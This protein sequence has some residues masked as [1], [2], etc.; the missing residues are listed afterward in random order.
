MSRSARIDYT[1][2][3]LRRQQIF[4]ARVR[5][6]TQPFYE[7]YREQQ[8]KLLAQGADAYLPQEMAELS[9]DLDTIAR[10]LNL[11]P[12]AAREVSFHVGRYIHGLPSILRE[13]K[14][15]FAEQERQKQEALDRATCEK[16]A[17]LQKTYYTFIAGL[18]PAD[19]HFA[20]HALADIEKK[21]QADAIDSES[22]LSAMLATAAREASRKAEVWRKKQQE[23][24]AGKA[25]A[26]RIDDAI[27]KVEAESIVAPQEKQVLIQNLNGLRASLDAGKDAAEV[28]EGAEAADKAADALMVTIDEQ[29]ALAQD[30][31]HQLMTQGFT[32]QQPAIKDGIVYLTGIAPDGTQAD[33]TIDTKGKGSYDFHGFR[34]QLCRQSIEEF[35]AQLSAIYN[36]S[37]FETQTIWEN[38]D[39]I[40]SGVDELP[41]SE[42]SL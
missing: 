19:A 32:L 22:N 38:L 41:V 15:A 3:K 27:A 8:A 25:A 26:S 6:N 36:T 5:R 2:E 17:G 28:L 11:D 9:H 14:K 4:E 30:I 10:L 37:L 31:C 7:R 42:R 20:R 34:G 35:K 13:A 29:Q 23:K 33:F 39:R 18:S 40:E 21:L 1:L 16:A 12:A 24:Q